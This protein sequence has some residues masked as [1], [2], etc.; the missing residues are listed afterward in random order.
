MKLRMPHILVQITR[1]DAEE[2]CINNELWCLQDLCDGELALLRRTE[3]GEIIALDRHND[4]IEI[5][6]EIQD[7]FV[8]YSQQGT[9][10]L[11]GVLN[12]RI[13][14]VFDIM[15]YLGLDMRILQY[16]DRYSTLAKVLTLKWQHSI[17]LVPTYFSLS[18]KSHWF[19]KMEKLKIK[20][21]VFKHIHNVLEKEKQMPM[22]KV[23]F[24]R[25]DAK[26]LS[27]RKRA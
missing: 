18:E 2:N 24:D 21:A 26:I 6:P 23:V 14:H 1:Q 25:P 10:T 27:F 9:M 13:F 15:E 16:K 12:G 4:P 17:L 19:E 5:L 22:F 20:G 11:V 7:A 8:K 3:D